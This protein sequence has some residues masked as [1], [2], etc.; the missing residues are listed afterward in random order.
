[1]Y[2]PRK[3]PLHEHSRSN[4]LQEVSNETEKPS[5]ACTRSSHLVSCAGEDRQLTAGWAASGRGGRANRRCA[6][7]DGHGRVAVDRAADWRWNRRAANGCDGHNRRRSGCWHDGR[8]RAGLGDGRDWDRGRFRDDWGNGAGLGDGG[9]WHWGGRWNDRRSWAG[10]C[11]VNLLATVIFK[12]AF[13]C[14]GGTR[15][16]STR[17][18]RSR[19]GG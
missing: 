15:W 2:I 16:G 14:S 5:K 9:D 17:Q 12:A 8:D 19:L 4:C 6:G 1:M 11:A 13:V 18:G 3:R 7:G 10:G